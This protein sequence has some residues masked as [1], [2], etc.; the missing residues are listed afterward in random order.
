VLNND[1]SV[2]VTFVVFDLIR[3]DG[4]DLTDRPF[5]ER[6]ELLVSLGLDSP[7]WPPQRRSKTATP[8][9]PACAKTD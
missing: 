7:G 3:L 5:E 1:F 9:T 6:R 8:S 2:P 4:T